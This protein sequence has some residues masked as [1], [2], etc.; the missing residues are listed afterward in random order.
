VPV[1]ELDWANVEAFFPVRAIYW[2]ACP[3][4]RDDYSSTVV[5]VTRAILCGS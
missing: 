3:L 1:F 4:N 5:V 2:G